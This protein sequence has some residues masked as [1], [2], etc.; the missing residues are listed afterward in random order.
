MSDGPDF[1]D[2][3]L[4]RSDASFRSVFEAEWLAHISRFPENFESAAQLRIGSRFRPCLVAWG[5]FL[6]GGS[7]DPETRRAVA[8]HAVYVELLHKATLLIDDL[9]DND[10]ARHGKPAFHMEF[11]DNEAILFAIYLIGDCVSHLTEVTRSLNSEPQNRILALLG[12]AIKEMASGAILEGRL[13]PDGLASI[14]SVTKI[15]EMQTIS[16]VKN[17]L[18][19]GYHLG[20]GDPSSLVNVDSLGHDAGYMFQVLNDLEPFY[21]S[22]KNDAYKGRENSDFGGLRKNHLVATHLDSLNEEDRRNLLAELT[23]DKRNT[24]AILRPGLEKERTLAKIGQNL[25]LVR[26]N[27]N[28]VVEQIPTPEPCKIGFRRFVDFVLE[29][30]LSRLDHEPRYILSE[31]LIR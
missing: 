12:E 23:V 31:I 7:Y 4:G 22:E 3:I 9:I 26:K 5:H 20:E 24:R 27:I 6:A 13:A 25:S 16:L 17:G 19:V 14:D 15:I 29:R 10:P 8:R 28:R 1:H 18:V 21:G 2:L 11:N 30:A